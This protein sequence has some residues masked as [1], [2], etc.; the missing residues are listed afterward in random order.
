[1]IDR[2]V[3]HAELI[4]VKGDADASNRKALDFQPLWAFHRVFKSKRGRGSCRQAEYIC[5][6][7][8]LHQ[9]T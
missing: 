7:Y 2:F 8:V 1:M 5:V 9:P 3:H 4:V 6:L